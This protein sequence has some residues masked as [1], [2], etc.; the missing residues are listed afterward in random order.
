MKRL[1]QVG[2]GFTIGALLA[3]AAFADQPAGKAFTY[4]GELIQDGQPVNQA[5]DFQFSLHDDSVAGNQVGGAIQLLNEPVA[6]GR[7]TVVLD[8]G[9]AFDGKARWLGIAVRCPAGVGP[10]TPLTPRQELTPAPYAIGLSLPFQGVTDTNLGGAFEIVNNDHGWAGVF[11]NN[12]PANTDAA[13][14]VTSMGGPAGYFWNDSGGTTLI[15]NNPYSGT[16]VHSEIQGTSDYSRAIYGALLNDNGGDF[17]AAL[18]GESL[19]LTSQSIG[20]WGSSAGNGYG[21]YGSSLTGRGVFGE[22]TNDFGFGVYGIGNG[23]TGTGVYGLHSAVNGETPGVWGR[24][25]SMYPDA[26]GVLGEALSPNGGASC[27]VIGRSN[28]RS[29][30]GV[31]GEGVTGVQGF[32]SETGVY[33]HASDTVGEGV[34]GEG[35]YGVYGLGDNGGAG[36][37]GEAANGSTYGVWAI[38]Q[39]GRLSQPA[40]RADNYDGPGIYALAGRA[41][42]GEGT[43][44][45]VRGV[46]W[47]DTGVGG[48]FVNYAEGGVALSV[49]GR[50]EVEGTMAVNVLEIMGGADLAERFEF[51][52]HAEPGMVVAIDPA[53]PGKLR[54]SREAY[55]KRVAGVISGANELSAGVVLGTE[56][57]HAR[58]LPVALTGRVWV[59]CDTRVAGVSPGD[60]VTTSDI[61]GFAMPVLDRAAAE[62]AVIGKAMTGLALGESGMVL[63]LVNLQ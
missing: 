27:G 30:I 45:G 19:S 11:R 10:Y 61:P 54:V 2:L 42:E 38:G 24:T 9:D 15:A 28:G 3:A 40:L 50:A 25:N 63:V 46:T 20:V 29:G 4:Q 1:C 18:R 7:F 34:R 57:G 56:P 31:K 14:N 51:S 5:C 52:E 16:G 32:G 22:A 37:T 58:N 36:V 49:Y 47:E 44:F 23:F 13:L 55:N 43:E 17:A 26:S 48:T 53:Q 62:G 35:T 39:G 33:G 41:I 6:D 8:F 21:V 59:H 60:F 12:N